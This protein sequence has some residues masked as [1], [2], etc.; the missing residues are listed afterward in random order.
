MRNL[1]PTTSAST[2]DAKMP[3]Q[4]LKQ[5]DPQAVSMAWAL[6][7]RWWRGLSHRIQHLM[8]SQQVAMQV[9][10]KTAGRVFGKFL[11][12]AHVC[13][14]IFHRPI[15][16]L[17]IDHESKEHSSSLPQLLLDLRD[18]DAQQ[19]LLQKMNKVPPQLVHFAM[20][21]GT[22]SRARDRKI[23]LNLRKRGAPEPPP[24]RSATHP[25]GMPNLSKFHQA[26]VESANLLLFFVVAMLEQCHIMSIHVVLENPARSWIWAALAEIVRRHN[27]VG[28]RQWYN[29]LF[30]FVFSACEH[31]GG[32]PKET[33]FLTSLAALLKLEKRY[34]G[35]HEHL[36]YNI[37]WKDQRWNFDT[38]KE[39]EYPHLLCQRYVAL[40]CKH[41]KLP[42]VSTGKHRTATSI[43]T[44]QQPKIARLIPEFVHIQIFPK[45]RSHT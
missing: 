12:G 9:R 15:S 20:P 17:P 14:Y 42:V 24:L 3:L 19:V 6:V 18:K 29:N 43:A 23:P 21:C 34:S 31:G 27:N 4:L 22:G 26:K 36:P 40:V 39:A 5:L 33:R 1:N 41:F 32:R 13:P 7:V 2:C 38:S 37:S 30:D 35:N 45:A 10:P 16:T 11:Q 44:A 25:L 28:F 8:G